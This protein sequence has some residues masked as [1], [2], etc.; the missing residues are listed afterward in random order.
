MCIE[1]SLHSQ[2]CMQCLAQRQ[3]H[4]NP[5]S[6]PKQCGTQTK[7]RNK[8]KKRFCC[9]CCFRQIFFCRR[10]LV[11]ISIKNFLISLRRNISNL[12]GLILICVSRK[13]WPSHIH[14]IS[15]AKPFFR[16]LFVFL[17]DFSFS[18]IRTQRAPLAK[19]EKRNNDRTVSY[20]K[21]MHLL[22]LCLS[23]VPPLSVYGI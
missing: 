18:G 11:E 22:C 15:N 9:C 19:I 16:F 4:P 6:K 3:S 17:D 21:R 8:K 12:I 10:F 5:N 1:S 2:N 13:H 20:C 14:I 7:A 23:F